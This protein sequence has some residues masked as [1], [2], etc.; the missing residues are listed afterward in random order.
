MIEE[1]SKSYGVVT[2][3]QRGS[4][5]GGMENHPTTVTEY[6]EDLESVVAA[7]S[8]SD[9][10]TILLGQTFGAAVVI[11]ELPRGVAVDGATRRR[12][13]RLLMTYFYPRHLC[14]TT[15][16][17]D[18]FLEGTSKLNPDLLSHFLGTDLFE[19][20]GA[21]RN[22]DRDALLESIRQPVLLASGTYDYYIEEDVR[23]MAARLPAR[24][25]WFSEMAGHSPWI[26]DADSFFAAVKDFLQ[27]F[28]ARPDASTATERCA[29]PRD[30]SPRQNDALLLPRPHRQRRGICVRRR[31]IIR[32]KIK[33]PR[34]RP[35]QLKPA[36]A[37]PPRRPT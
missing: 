1:L 35:S 26:E 34:G 16:W 18:S 9:G 33:N 14:R 13:S 27:R 30:R 15:P 29:L 32:R 10:A 6:A 11:E 8:E 7:L 24:E 3:P 23:S 20:E 31:R 22:W 2:Y 36:T 28:H 17:P 21:L 4:Y 25:L 19:P 5:D 12:E 37:A